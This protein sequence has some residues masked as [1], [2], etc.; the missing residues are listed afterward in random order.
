MVNKN[1]IYTRRLAAAVVAPFGVATEYQAADF[2]LVQDDIEIVGAYLGISASLADI[3]CMGGG[4]VHADL[5][6]VGLLDQDGQILQGMAEVIPDIATNFGQSGQL[7][8]AVMFPAGLRIPVREE[9][10]IYLN[11]IAFMANVTVGNIG[12]CLH[13]TIYYI[14]V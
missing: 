6:Q 13:G 10:Y 2:W 5:S 1:K 11:G 9:G 14:R 4:C 8:I 7:N 3:L 12:I